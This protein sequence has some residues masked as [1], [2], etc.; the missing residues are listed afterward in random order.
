MSA[1]FTWKPGFTF[2]SSSFLFSFF[3]WHFLKLEKKQ[4]PDNSCSPP[5]TE[6]LSILFKIS[7]SEAACGSHV[8]S[9]P[10]KFAWVYQLPLV[11]NLGIPGRVPAVQIEL[12]P[13]DWPC[14]PLCSPPLSFDWMEP[15]QQEMKREA[16]SPGPWVQLASWVCSR[17]TWV[18]S[19]P[20]ALPPL[21]PCFLWQDFKYSNSR[22]FLLPKYYLNLKRIASWLLENNLE[23]I[24]K[25]TSQ[26]VY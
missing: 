22:R 20:P 4:L 11:R 13:R 6:M 15:P 10:K 1:L 3:L 16:L 14:H 5:T 19:E 2:F 26:T 17:A 9:R 12:P 18:C 8:S 23:F 21:S 25:V 24:S 7:P